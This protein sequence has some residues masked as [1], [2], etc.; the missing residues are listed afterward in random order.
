MCFCPEKEDE[1]S[2]VYGLEFML[3]LDKMQNTNPLMHTKFEIFGQS[4]LKVIQAFYTVRIILYIGCSGPIVED[5]N[6][7]YAATPDHWTRYPIY[8]NIKGMLRVKKLISLLNN[9]LLAKLHNYLYKYP[10]E[11]F[12]RLTPADA[13]AFLE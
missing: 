7:L 1:R 5:L 2:F 3:T 8:V 12:S 4:I 11:F 10:P 6:E 13:N 9:V